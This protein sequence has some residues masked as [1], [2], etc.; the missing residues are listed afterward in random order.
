MTRAAIRDATVIRPAAM[1]WKAHAA[2]RTSGGVA[3]V[4]ASLTESIYLKA[5]GEIVWLGPP[6]SPRHPRAVLAAASSGRHASLSFDL[7]GLEPWRPTR[8]A[9]DRAS[10]RTGAVD[11]AARLRRQRDGA[12]PP[13]FAGLLVGAPLDFP[14]H[15]AAGPVA[16]M[17]AACEVD[18]AGRAASAAGA[19]L[20]LGPG[21]TPAGDDFVGGMLFAR[22]AL[23]P[24]AAWA[25]VGATIVA[26]ARA[27]THPISAALLE[28]LAAG[29]S[30]EPLHGLVPA[31]A[32][33]AGGEAWRAVEQLGR[34][35]SSSGWDMLT[36]VLVGLAGTS[37][38]PPRR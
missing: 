22:H 1:G 26:W 31:L 28:D 27:R 36:G 16:E 38:L 5:C 25:S 35:G 14:L 13:G 6:R 18:D 34:L 37:A 21:L 2:L 15:H 33:R 8:I 23:G 32:Q 17:A 11:L 12:P 20:G 4:M 7:A 9:L 10:L 29:E 30:H 3:R 19:L 24:D